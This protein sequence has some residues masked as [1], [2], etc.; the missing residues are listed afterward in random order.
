MVVA[1]RVQARR[2]ERQEHPGV[3]L[4]AGHSVARRPLG[5]YELI[6]QQLG[7]GRSELHDWHQR[8]LAGGESG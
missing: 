6:G 8:H 2:H 3:K 1:R 7:S 5:V 4:A